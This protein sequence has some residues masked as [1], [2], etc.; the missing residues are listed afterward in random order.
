MEA[1]YI[2]LSDC[3]KQVVWIYT[4]MEEL[5]YFLEPILIC[6]DNQGSTFMADNSVMES[7]SKHIDL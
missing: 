6:G 5:G 3:S 2:V 7:C 4:I 1:E